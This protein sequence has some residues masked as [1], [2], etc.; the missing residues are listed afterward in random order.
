M[1]QAEENTQVQ[2]SEERL[3]VYNVCCAKGQCLITESFL[4]VVIGSH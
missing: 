2:K 1:I 3:L 4:L